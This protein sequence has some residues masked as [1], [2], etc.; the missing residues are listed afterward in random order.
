MDNSVV[1]AGQGGSIGGEEVGEG[2]GGINGDG[3][4][5]KK[6]NEGTPKNSL[7]LLP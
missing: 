4:R 2:I 7:S 3:K 1:I 6:K 5:K